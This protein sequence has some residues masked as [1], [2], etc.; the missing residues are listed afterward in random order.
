MTTQRISPIA[1]LDHGLYQ[2]TILLSRN[3]HR[4]STRRAFAV[5]ASR[6]RLHSIVDIRRP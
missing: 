6:D 1:N 4:R 2:R 3:H 5:E